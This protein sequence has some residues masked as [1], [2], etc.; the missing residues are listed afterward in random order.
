MTQARWYHSTRAV[1]IGLLTVGPFA[2]P[3]VWG[4]PH[5]KAATKV[6]ISVVVLLLTILMVYLLIIL[7]I[8]LMGQIEELMAM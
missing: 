7:Y 8:R 1:V 4:N 3:L 2:L 5:F 6:I